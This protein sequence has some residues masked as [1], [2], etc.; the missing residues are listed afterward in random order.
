MDPLLTWSKEAA[1]RFSDLFVCTGTIVGVKVEHRAKEAET[2]KQTILAKMRRNY[3][4]ELLKYDPVVR[5]YRDLFWSLC[6]EP[7][8]TRPA[9]EALLRRVLHGSDIPS[10]SNVVDAYNLAS[11]ET[12]IPLSGFDLDRVSPPLE[13][14]FSNERDEFRGIGMNKPMKFSRKALLVADTKQILCI[15]PCRDADVT[16]INGKTR[17]VLIIGYGAPSISGD[18]LVDAVEKALTYIKSTASGVKET[19]NVFRTR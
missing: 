13:I 8:K 6:I 9:G 5:A 15:Y 12:T 7:T 3:K 17:S 1:K 16:K 10:I 19:V 2:L 18:Q 14:R 4:A 11:L